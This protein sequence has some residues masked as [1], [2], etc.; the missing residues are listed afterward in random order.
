MTAREEVPE[1]A[2]HLQAEYAA[3][4]AGSA[5]QH[6]IESWRDER[7]TQAAAAWVLATVFVRYCEDNG[8]IG[9]AVPRRARGPAGRGGGATRG[10]LPRAPEPSTTATGCSPPSTHLAPMP[11]RRR[12]ACSTGGTTRCGR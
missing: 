9:P 10:V 3:R 7:V 5:P 8:L 2:R 11:T 6:A 1:F 12:R 4:E